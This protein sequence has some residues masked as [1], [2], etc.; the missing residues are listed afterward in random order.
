MTKSGGW[1]QHKSR[2]A[3]GERLKSGAQDVLATGCPLTRMEMVGEI[4][5]SLWAIANNGVFADS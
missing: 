3:R 4:R 2:K 1:F 5:T